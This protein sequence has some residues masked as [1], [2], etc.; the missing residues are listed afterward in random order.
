MKWF[1]FERVIFLMI[2]EKFILSTC[3]AMISSN[4][5]T[6]ITELIQQQEHD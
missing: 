2:E 5:T 4:K 1:P 3:S 6:A